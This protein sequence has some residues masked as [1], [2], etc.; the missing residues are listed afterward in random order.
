MEVEKSVGLMFKDAL[1]RYSKKYIDD[2]SV[3]GIKIDLRQQGIDL[4]VGTRFIEGEAIFSVCTANQNCEAADP[5]IFNLLT[6]TLEKIGIE[7]ESGAGIMIKRNAEIV[8]TD[9]GCNA[10]EDKHEEVVV[11]TSVLDAKPRRTGL[12]AKLFGA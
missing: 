10:I 5:S 9:V 7:S 4:I 3:C 2:S 8:N 12:M 6:S 11:A 1:E